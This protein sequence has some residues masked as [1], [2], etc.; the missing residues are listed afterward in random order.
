MTV[1]TSGAHTAT[2][3][4]RR[5]LR[6]VGVFVALALAL[7]WLVALPLW[8]GDG[9]ATPW[10]PLVSVAMM[11]TPTIAA[12]V[13]VFV[14]ERPQRK[15]WTLGLGPLTPARRV[16]GYAALGI[17]V[18]IA[19]VLVALPVGALLGVYPADFGNLS[20]FRQLLDARAGAASADG[21]P[22]SPG[23]LV[24]LQLATLPVAAFVN[25]LPALGE[26]IGWRGWLLPKLMQLGTPRPS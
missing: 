26:E 17:V 1:D 3:T 2:R 6:S 7:A 22:I 4:D 19:L 23:T 20:G 16:F 8:F 25:L 21:L 15:A 24:A 13:V 14:V 9:L 5:N 11:T 10:F 12:L 18:S